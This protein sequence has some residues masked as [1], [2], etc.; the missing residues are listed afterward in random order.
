MI[1][2]AYIIPS[3]YTNCTKLQIHLVKIEHESIFLKGSDSDLDFALKLFHLKFIKNICWSKLIRPN[4]GEKFNFSFSQN[5][6]LL[7]YFFSIC[8][9]KLEWP[10]FETKF[11]FSFSQWFT[12]QIFYILAILYRKNLFPS[13]LFHSWFM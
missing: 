11:N 13:V 9:P 5:V 1:K 8:W 10:N 3:V 7:N 12:V 2:K 6:Q 4:F